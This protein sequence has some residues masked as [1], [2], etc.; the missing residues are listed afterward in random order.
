[1]IGCD[2]IVTA[3]KETLS[4]MRDGRTH[5][6]LNTH[7]TPTAAFVTQPEL[8]VPGGRLRR[9]DRATPSAPAARRPFDADALA[10]QLMGDAIYTNPMMLGYAWQKGLGAAAPRVADA[11]DRTQRRAG[12]QQQGRLRVGPPRRARSGRR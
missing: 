7:S 1:M 2:P 8:A 9:R 10:T 3:S 11:R 12:R 4:R 6:A 5:V